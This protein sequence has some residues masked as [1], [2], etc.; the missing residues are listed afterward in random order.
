ML[1]LFNILRLTFTGHKAETISA[2]TYKRRNIPDEEHIIVEK[3]HEGIISKNDFLTVQTMMKNR[4]KNKGVKPKPNNHLFS[5]LLFCND[6]GKG[7]H[8]KANRK[9][10]VCGT[11]DK[12]GTI[13]CTS[14]IVREK[15]L[16]K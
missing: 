16:K 3:T 15:N 5:G 10:Y 1:E 8:F 2:N 13:K 11:F 9:G 7:M 12:W 4:T 14:H 6:C